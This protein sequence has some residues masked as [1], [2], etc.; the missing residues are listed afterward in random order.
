[1][2]EGC[3]RCADGS[4]FP[5]YSVTSCAVWRPHADAPIVSRH[6]IEIGTVTY[7]DMPLLL[8][9]EG[10][11]TGD[12]S[13]VVMVLIGVDDGY[14]AMLREGQSAEM[15]ARGTSSRGRVVS[16]F[17]R[18]A[19]GNT[20]AIVHF[21]RDAPETNPWGSVD[22][23]IDAGIHPNTLYMLRPP[24]ARA[25]TAKVGSGACNAMSE[26]LTE[27][28][29]DT[30]VPRRGARGSGRGSEGRRPRHPVR[31]VAMVRALISPSRSMS[32]CIVRR[33]DCYRHVSATSDAAR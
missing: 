26:A 7:G 9:S 6:G 22:I 33:D 15:R 19:V 21:G 14:G 2:L 31:F 18:S 29:S 8:S 10:I 13:P 20:M 30:V 17:N 32:A 5:C 11:V 24:G 3:R 12:L 25:D 28:R 4:F 1:M 27:W 16:V 23:T